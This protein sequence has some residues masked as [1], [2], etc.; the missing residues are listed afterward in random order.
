MSL[1]SVEQLVS[2]AIQR[3]NRFRVIDHVISSSEVVSAVRKAQPDVA[4]IS[5]RLRWRF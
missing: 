1:G 4:V 3:N 2:D 5:T